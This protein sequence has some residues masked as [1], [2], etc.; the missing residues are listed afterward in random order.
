MNLVIIVV[1]KIYSLAFALDDYNS[2]DLLG[3]NSLFT[4]D[5]MIQEKFKDTYDV[6]RV[7]DQM[8]SEFCL[9][10]RRKIENKLLFSL[11]S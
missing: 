1:K 11:S 5:K 4:L 9:E 7:Y 8:I 2:I 10:N 3:S 6:R